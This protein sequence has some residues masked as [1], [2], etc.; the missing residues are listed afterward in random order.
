MLLI[1]LQALVFLITRKN[2][3]YVHMTF[4]AQNYLRNKLLKFITLVLK[5]PV[6]VMQ[7]F[8][9]LLTWMLSN[10]LLN[11]FFIK[12]TWSFTKFNLKVFNLESEISLWRI[13][14]SLILHLHILFYMNYPS[15]KMSAAS[16]CIISMKI[17]KNPK[18]N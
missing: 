1:E 15:T 2:R 11:L 18:I 9:N 4:L 7:V 10:D 17:F 8:L 14:F 5:H 13:L 3:T 16:M 6:Y 12:G